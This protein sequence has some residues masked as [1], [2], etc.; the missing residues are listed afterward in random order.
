MMM[1]EITVGSFAK[2]TASK[3][4]AE[5]IGL[6][7]KVCKKFE[8]RYGDGVD[9]WLCINDELQDVEGITVGYGMFTTQGLEPI[10]NEKNH[11]TSCTYQ[12]ELAFHRLQDT[13]ELRKIYW[14]ALGQLR[15][16]SNDQVIP[17]DFEE[18]PCCKHTEDK[19]HA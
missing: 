8:N 11:N 14:S 4:C 16:D 5:N 2:T 19:D 15:F 1:R 9:W 13:P 7:V 17:P 3:L 12:F 6:V 18:C 10:I